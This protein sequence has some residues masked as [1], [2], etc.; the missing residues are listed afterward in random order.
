MKNGYSLRQATHSDFDFIFEVNKVTMKD[1]VI[2]T[3]GK[4]DDQWQRQYFQQKFY[5]EHGFRL[6][7][8]NG[9]RFS[10]TLS[11]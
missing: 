9:E 4:W 8:E 7:K 1:H 6:T 2:A 10:M 3:W 11:I 5:T